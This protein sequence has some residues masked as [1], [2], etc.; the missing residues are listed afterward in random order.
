M[1]E[2]LQNKAFEAL[3][4]IEASL[5]VQLV[6]DEKDEGKAKVKIA[7]SSSDP[8]LGVLH[9]M[10]DAK[11]GDLATIMITGTVDVRAGEDLKAGDMV[12]P[13]GEGKAVKS[14]SGTIGRV[15]YSTSKDSLAVITLNVQ[16]G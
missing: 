10:Y 11:K 15:L 8:I 12:G 9:R 3:E 1:Q 4:D 6:A 5:I 14:E 16:K 13:N 7:T 2:Q